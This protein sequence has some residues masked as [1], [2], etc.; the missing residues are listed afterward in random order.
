MVDACSSGFNSFW[1][2]A[3]GATNAETVILIRYTWTDQ[4][5]RIDN[6]RGVDVFFAPDTQAFKTCDAVQPLP[7]V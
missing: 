3:A 5:Y 4:V 2:F 6:P 1:V 7:P